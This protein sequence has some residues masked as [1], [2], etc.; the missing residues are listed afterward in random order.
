MDCLLFMDDNLMPATTTESSGRKDTL[1]GKS[2]SRAQNAR[3]VDSATTTDS[4]P[5]PDS[6]PEI[7]PSAVILARA[8]NIRAMSGGAFLYASIATVLG[9]EYNPQAFV[10]F[11]NKLLERCGDPTDPIEI[12]LVEQL[13][14]AHFSIG[15]LQI[16]A[17]VIDNTKL[18]IAFGDSATRLLGE[19][20]RCTLALEDFRAK[21]A[22]RKEQPV[23]NAAKK[24]APAAQDGEPWS[25]T[26][27]TSSSN[28]KKKAF[29][30]KLTTNEEVP[31]CIRQR[32]GY[33]ANDALKQ[34]VE[35]G[36]NGKG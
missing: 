6:E 10:V 11:R 26:D 34:T 27:G 8:E 14:L 3:D 15:R 31:E 2:A 12:M 36:G 17:S 24:T 30:N 28:G 19:F 9:A 22:A 5:K 29:D 18:A 1:S 7:D 13:A 23:N 33:A 35:I 20:R 16:K 4:K 25:S 21:Q 32:M